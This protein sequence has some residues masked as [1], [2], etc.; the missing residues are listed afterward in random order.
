MD[1]IKSEP[2]NYQ[3]R[4]ELATALNGAGKRNEAAHELLEIMKRD[5]SWNDEAAKKQLLRFFES[6]G[7]DDPATLQGR[8]QLSTLLFS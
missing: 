2:D 3:A 5:K 4:Y 1:K 6:W 7:F 8:R